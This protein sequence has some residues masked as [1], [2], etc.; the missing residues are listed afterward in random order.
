M[1]I[2]KIENDVA[3]LKKQAIEKKKKKDDRGAIA[4]LR[5]AKMY[6]K[7]LAKLEGQ[8]MMLDQQVIMMQG[9]QTDQAVMG[10]LKTAKNTMDQ[11][12]AGM[13][14]DQMEDLLDDLKE[15]QAD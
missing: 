14:L 8:S 2:K 10:G 6:E 13:N 11:V 7:E 1:R 9:V 5:K 12:R 15:Q 3:A 4:A